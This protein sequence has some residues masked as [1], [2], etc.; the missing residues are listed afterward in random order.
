MVWKNAGIY[1]RFHCGGYHMDQRQRKNL[2]NS[3]VSKMI[4][5]K[6]YQMHLV[7]LPYGQNTK[8]ELSIAYTKPHTFFSGLL[9]FSWHP[10][11]LIGV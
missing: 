10:G 11:S 7:I 9:P 8:A 5:L 3:S 2:G 1:H 4:I 6:W